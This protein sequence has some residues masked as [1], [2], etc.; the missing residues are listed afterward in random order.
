MNFDQSLQEKRSGDNPFFRLV[1]T[2]VIISLVSILVFLAFVNLTWPQQSVCGLL[3]LLLALWLGRSSDSYLITLTLMIMSMFATLRYGIWRLVTIIKLF[4]DPGNHWGLLDAMFISILYGA[5][6]Y[7]FAIL[8]LGYLQTIWPLRRAPVPLPDSTEDWPAVDIV[9]PTYNEPLDVVRYTAFAAL[10]VDWPADKLRVVILDDGRR[11]EFRQF[12]MEAGI[13]YMTRDDNKHAKAGNINRALKNL[14]A[15]Y[16]AI[17]DCDHV[18]TRSFLQMTIGWFL[19]DK[20]LAMLQTPHHFYSPDPFERNLAQFR[21]IPNEGEL[22]YGIVQDGNDFWNA[23]FFCGSCAVLRRTALDEIGGIAVETVTEDAH[24]SLRMQMNGWNTAYIGIPQAAGLATERLSA[25]VVQRVRWARGMIQILRVDNPL[26]AKGLSLSQR[27]CYFNAMTHFLYALPRLI[28]LTSPL[29][30]LLLSHSNVPGYWAAILAYALPHLTLSNITNSRIQGQHRHSFWNE[31]YETVLSPYILLPTLFA[32]I[33]PKFGKF[34]VTA[35]GGIVAK[36]FFDVRIATPYLWL[37]VFNMLGLLMAIPRYFWWDKA[38]PGTVIMNAMWVVFNIIM[39]GVTVAVARESQ[40]RRTNV[41][42]TMR[43]PVT[44]LL[45]NGSSLV[46]ETVDM[47]S[48]GVALQ[49]KEPLE[50][51]HGSSL[52]LIF[53][54]RNTMAELPVTVVHGGGTVLRTKFEPLSIPEQEMLTMV[55][56][57]RADNWLG[58]G[59]SREIDQP[60]RSLARI[61]QLSMRGLRGAFHSMFHRED[62]EAATPAVA[63]GRVAGIVILLSLLIGLASWKAHGQTIAPATPAGTTAPTASVPDLG[64]QAVAQLRAAPAP[65]LGS[66]RDVFTLREAATPAAIDMHGIDS[67]HSIFFSLPQTHVVKKARLHVY[68]NYSTSL[69]ADLSHIKVLVNGTLVA[70]IDLPK[71]TVNE[72]T[73][74]ERDIDVPAELLVRSNQLTFNFIGHYVYVCEDPANTTL[75]S[76]VETGTYMVMEG[77]LLP[78]QDD[79]KLLPL[80]LVD[81]SLVQP[82]SLP[83]VFSTQ[84]SLKAVQAAGIVT[85]YF[86]VLSESRP[87]RYPTFIGELP[88]GNVILIAEDPNSLPASLKLTN[89]GSP[90]IAIRANPND[91]YGKVLVLTGADGDQLIKA[92]QALALNG[93]TLQG[94]TATIDAGRYSLPAKQGADEAPRWARTDHQTIQLWDYSTAESLQGDGSVPLYTYFRIAPDLYYSDKANVLLKLIY[95]YNSIP[96]GPISSMQIRANNSYIASVPL[97]PGQDVSKRSEANIAIPVVNL[98]PFSN[99][100]SFDFTFQLLK[101]G[102]CQDTTPINMQGSILRDSYLDIKGLPH[103]APMPNLEVFANAGFPF[104]RFADLGE[105]TVVLPPNPSPQEIELYVTLLSFFGQ[106]TGYPATRVTVADASVMEK[107]AA[108]DFLVIGTGEDQPAFAKLGD[109]LPVNVNG[110]QIR[111][112]DTQGFFAPLHRAWWKIQQADRTETGEMVASGAPDA[113][114]EGIESPYSMKRSIVVINLREGK[115]YDQFLTTFVKISQSSDISGTVS[116]LRGA[117]FQSFRIGENTYHVGMLPWWMQLTIWL[118]QV[119][120][121][122]ALVVLG[123]SFLLAVWARMALRRRA[124]ARLQMNEH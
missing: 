15:P 45:P 30:Y 92:A 28:F 57:S 27:L 94:D 63:P 67:Q 100:L 32:L 17:F 46:G 14:Y 13:E 9:I 121:L 86:G 55:L 49:L 119:P 40:Q 23:T 42:V 29:I 116:V 31:I 115:V 82:P 26:F 48:S 81:P 56:Y 101:K 91:A 52:R 60:M 25:H 10:N 64:E 50:V 105:T 80:P 112:R 73:I 41:R 24:T 117:E 124:R 38:H 8:F 75:W 33:N 62:E 99:S 118:M 109:K 20:N 111:V 54:M 3:M 1:R 77:D 107:G 76:R 11:E 21:V 120:W 7:A 102:G 70:I 68:Y 95:R 18:P 93:G 88:T 83:L 104:T 103:Y 2:L 110:G 65:G 114:I 74:L 43:I 35:K 36:S 106:Q 78:L 113:I 39:L 19:R 97:I 87:I 71:R 58:W 98:R 84:P 72:N 51:S 69:I 123:I 47:S 44:V 96:I 90:T 6:L 4:Q 61:I 12:S 5:E 34:N 89:I 122:V 79:L 59:E 53:P 37:L 108:K 66:F 22:F 85:S 16:V